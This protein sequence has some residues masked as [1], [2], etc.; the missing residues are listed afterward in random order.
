MRVNKLALLISCSL[1][2]VAAQATQAEGNSDQRETQSARSVTAS[3]DAP[4]AAGLTDFQWFRI[5]PYVEKSYSL[6]AAGRL[7]AALVEVARAREIVPDHVPL[8]MHEVELLIENDNPQRALEALQPYLSDPQARRVYAVLLGRSDRIARLSDEQFFA[9]LTRLES[10]QQIAFAGGYLDARGNTLSRTQLLR[11]IDVI[12]PENVPADRSTQ[13]AEYLFRQ[14]GAEDVV[15]LLEPRCIPGSNRGEGCSDRLRRQ[16]IQALVISEQFDGIEQWLLTLADDDFDNMLEAT[17]ERMIGAQRTDALIDLLVTIDERQ[18]LKQKWGLVLFRLAVDNDEVPL[19]LSLAQR[20][21]VNCLSHAELLVQDRQMQRASKRLHQCQPSV[22]EENRYLVLAQQIGEPGLLES[23]QLSSGD[24]QRTR[25]S[26]LVDY[27]EERNQRR[28]LI[29]ILEGYERRDLDMQRFLAQ[30]YYENGQTEKALALSEQSWRQQQDVASLDY[31][32]YILLN[33][34]RYNELL[35][36]A[37]NE[38]WEDKRTELAAS[39]ISARL[40]AGIEQAN[41]GISSDEL[42]AAA[43]RWPDRRIASQVGE[44]LIQR[45]D[46]SAATGIR[47]QLDELSGH[48]LDSYCLSTAPER[49]NA[50]EQYQDQWGDSEWLRGAV[51]AYETG[52]YSKTLDYLQNLS[53]AVERGAYKPLEL[54]ALLALGDQDEAWTRWEALS[55][56]LNQDE[57]IIGVEI[58]LGRD[59][60]ESINAALQRVQA[61]EAPRL[62]LPLRLRLAEMDGDLEQQLDLFKRLAEDSPDDPYYLLAQ[63]HVEERLGRYSAAGTTFDVAFA[64]YPQS[65]TATNLQQAAYVNSEA[66]RDHL[67]RQQLQEVIDIGYEQGQQGTQAFD[68]NQR[69]YRQVESPFQV[70]VAGWW[71]ESTSLSQATGNDFQADYFLST[72]LEYDLDYGRER[73]SNLSVFANLLSAGDS[74]FFDSNNLDVGVA[75]KPFSKH[76]TF[77]RVATRTSFDGAGTRVYLRGSTDLLASVN[78]EKRWTED[79]RIAEQSLYLDWIFFPDEQTS[80][81]YGRY[82]PTFQLAGAQSSFF[83]LGAYPFVQYQWTNDTVGE[84]RLTDTRVG[85][86]FVWRQPLGSSRYAGW[87]AF[88]EVGL[89]WQYVVNSDIAGAS[90]NGL[91]LRFAVYF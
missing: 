38:T 25:V 88:S 21:P 30:A 27:Y 83:K 82:Q 13:V 10:D 50:L 74:F 24:A 79:K 34:E 70:S 15:T 71:G 53:P 22:S 84:E 43:Q 51:L 12:G 77:L 11:L 36:L 7:D 17:A 9:E 46:C 28:D 58:A 4:I 91:L 87:Q 80:G 63:A 41:T 67:A 6:A 90:D 2:C 66:R 68:Q 56:P 29:R 1:I 37:V 3:A 31:Y 14:G 8:L 18:S 85:L 19:A 44:V 73:D 61:S 52:N 35:S 48:Q 33:E 69:F 81:F 32:T 78:P 39:D 89:E 64:A 65:R 49:L 72:M 5:F 47:R 55:E 60:R 54:S 59:D 76:L 62:A 86:G 16:L 42:V 40:N 75:W 20:Y 57:I 26:L 23:V 45:R